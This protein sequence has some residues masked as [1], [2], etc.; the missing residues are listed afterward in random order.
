MSQLHRIA[1]IADV[2]P[3]SSLEA[4]AA[5]RVIALFNVDGTFHAI[6]GICAHAGGPVGKGALDGCVV[7]CPW[8]GWQYDVTNGR[9]CLTE[10]IAQQSFPVTVE[11][12]DV[13][14]ELPEQ[15]A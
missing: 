15:N 1:D 13:F 4:A 2:P 9:H 6:D 11:G 12:D 10:N 14:V 3:G 5:G 7:T 8:H